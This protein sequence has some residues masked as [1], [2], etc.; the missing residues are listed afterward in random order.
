MTN[1][2]DPVSILLMSHSGMISRTL[3]LPLQQPR[4]APLPILVPMLLLHLI[5]LAQRTLPKKKDHR[6]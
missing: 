3:M 4:R 2:L 6:R 5:V 1:P